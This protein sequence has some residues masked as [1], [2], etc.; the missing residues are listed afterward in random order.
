MLDDISGRIKMSKDFRNLFIVTIGFITLLFALQT[1]TLLLL[2]KTL[3]CNII[4]LLR[5]WRVLTMTENSKPIE[6]KLLY[7]TIEFSVGED[8]MLCNPYNKP[9]RNIIYEIAKEFSRKTQECEELQY[10]LKCVTG[11]E[12]GY[13]ANSEFWEKHCDK[14][15]EQAEQKLEKIEKIEKIVKDFHYAIIPFHRG[16]NHEMADRIDYYLDKILQIID[17]VER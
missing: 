12:K 1:I 7:Q 14:L 13:K 10:Q 17:E 5:N 15:K 2:E 3:K 4:H 11:R 16:I 8:G 9:L 6:R